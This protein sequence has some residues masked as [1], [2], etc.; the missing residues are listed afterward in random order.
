MT[1]AIDGEVMRRVD[2]APSPARPSVDAG[3]LIV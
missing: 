2:E 3:D 1:D